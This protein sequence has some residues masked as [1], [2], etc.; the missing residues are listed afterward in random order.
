MVDKLRAGLIRKERLDNPCA[1]SAEIAVK[2][3][4]SREYVR[5]VLSHAGLS[6]KRLVQKHACINCGEIKCKR[7]GQNF[8]SNGCLQEFHKVTL[9]CDYCGKSFQRLLSEAYWTL[10]A[11]GK[12]KKKLWFCNKKCNGSYVARHYGF[13]A[14]PENT[15]SRRKKVKDE[16]INGGGSL[17][18]SVVVSRNNINNNIA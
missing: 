16:A 4:V 1:Y 7:I 12:G 13:I 17:M 18:T 8:C 5:Q 10:R 15:M 11:V 14:H 6:T 2:Y 9:I 3:G